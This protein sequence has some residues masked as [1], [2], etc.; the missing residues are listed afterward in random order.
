MRSSFILSYSILIVTGIGLLFQNHLGNGLII[1]IGGVLGLVII[2][3]AYPVAAHKRWDLL[4]VE[5]TN[6]ATETGDI[7]R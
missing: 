2:L 6:R 5:T 1:A 3:H 4:D 7:A